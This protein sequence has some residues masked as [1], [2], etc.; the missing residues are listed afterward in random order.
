MRRKA[1]LPLVI[2]SLSI[3]LPLLLVSCGNSDKIPL[4]GET[5]VGQVSGA[6]AKL[7]EGQAYQSKG[8][9]RKAISSYKKVVKNYPNSTAAPEALYAQANL[10]DKQGDLIK[11]FDSYQDLITGY[12][13]SNRYA[14]ALKRQEYVAYAAANGVIKNN[15]LGMKTNIAPSSV[16]K[17][18]DDVRDNAPKAASAPKAQ[19]TI[20]KVWQKSGN[21]EKAIAAFRR[22][23][24][25]YP[26]SIQAPEA[27]YQIGETLISKTK[28]GNKNKANYD[29]ATNIYNELIA[30]YPNHKR[31][32]DAKKR[33]KSLGGQEIQRSYNV[34]EFYRK[35]GENKSAILYYKEV[36]KQSKRGPLRDLSTQRIAELEAQ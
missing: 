23:S 13:A 20:G 24:S 4:Q 33:I 2:T 19:F 28:D 16:E 10:L 1:L 18:L 7:A 36:L 11:A 6:N 26:E 27:L 17:M 21:S 12:Q 3:P 34:A 30:R 22:I 14:S 32:A 8:K 35:K 5:A 29:N 9:N 15:F 25:D 31:A